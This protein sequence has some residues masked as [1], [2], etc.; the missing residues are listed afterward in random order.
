VE[1]RI[2][3]D[4]T[5]YDDLVTGSTDVADIV[6]RAELVFVPFVVLGELRAGFA[7]GKRVAENERVLKRFLMKDGIEVLF[8]DTQTTT[9]YAHVY[10]QLRKQG[11]PIPTNDMWIAALVIQHDLLL[12]S[13]DAHFDK[14]AQVSRV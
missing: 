1:V 13:R 14:V 6:E 9:S 10:A 5:R 2:A 12:C 3:L 7:A 4:T 8:A 11:T